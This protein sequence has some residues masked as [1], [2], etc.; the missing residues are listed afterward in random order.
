VLHRE[1]TIRPTVVL[2]DFEH[3]K[4]QLNVIRF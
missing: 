3:L 2:D 4:N 1:A